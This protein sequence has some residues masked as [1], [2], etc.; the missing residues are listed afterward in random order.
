MLSIN[1]LK[2]GTKIVF[3]NDPHEVVLAEHSKLGRGGG[4]VRAKLKN[5][6]TGGVID[7]TF[8]GNESITPADLEKKTVQF[9]YKDEQSY[10]FMDQS[11]FAQF[12]LTFD[13]VGESGTFIKEGT[14]VEILSFNDEPIAVNIPIKVTLSVTYTEPGLKG[15]TISSPSKPAELETGAKIF[16]PLFIKTGDKIIVDTRNGNYLERAK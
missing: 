12:S 8:K 4:F 5:L 1:D 2:L 11:T 13:Q 10:Y 9:L 3:N 16:V 15:D 7:Y 6:R 14:E